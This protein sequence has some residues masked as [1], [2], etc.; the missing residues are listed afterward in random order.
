MREQRIEHRRVRGA[1]RSR[2]EEE[3]ERRAEAVVGLLAERAGYLTWVRRQ[4]GRWI[5]VDAAWRCEGA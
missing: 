5:W 2:G 1:G 4:R 3:E